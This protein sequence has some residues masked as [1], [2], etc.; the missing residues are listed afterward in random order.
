MVKRDAEAIAARLHEVEQ[1]LH[2]AWEREAT[3]QLH[4]GPI[5]VIRV[6]TSRSWFLVLVSVCVVTFGSGVA[7]TFGKD[8]KELGVALVVGSI[9]ALASFIGQVWTVQVQ[10]ERQL[11][12]G[13]WGSEQRRYLRGLFREREK[14]AEQIGRTPDSPGSSAGRP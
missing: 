14:L 4:V 7:F 10:Q 11:D 8:T 3:W 5:R 13:L 9:F 1:E 12:E 2:E 6:M